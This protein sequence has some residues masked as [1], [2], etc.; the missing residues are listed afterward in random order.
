MKF[1]KSKKF[2]LTAAHLATGG[3][4]LA[5][6]ILFPPLLPLIVPIQAVINGVIPS[7][8]VSGKAIETPGNPPESV[9]MK[10]GKTI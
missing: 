3:A 10:T 2:W 9:S 5:L 4:S 1:F 7:P 8:L 6:V